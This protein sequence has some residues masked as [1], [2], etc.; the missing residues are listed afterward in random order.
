MMEAERNPPPKPG[1][2]DTLKPGQRR[3]DDEKSGTEKERSA[4]EDGESVKKQAEMLRQGDDHESPGKDGDAEK[5]GDNSEDDLDVYEPRPPKVLMNDSNA[6][7]ME[8]RSQIQ[9]YATNECV[10]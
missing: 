2:F 4:D 6:I 7:P 1:E 5:S 10:L 3:L 8:L 9:M